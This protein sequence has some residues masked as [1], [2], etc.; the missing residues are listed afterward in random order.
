MKYSCDICFKSYVQQK[1]LHLHMKNFHECEICY[2][3]FVD[4]QTK[5]LHEMKHTKQV[6]SNLF[7]CNACNLTFNSMILFVQHI[8]GLNRNF[9]TLKCFSCDKEFAS[10]KEKEIHETNE[11]FVSIFCDVCNVLFTSKNML[12]FHK[13][14]FHFDKRPFTCCVCNVSFY[15]ENRLIEHQ[16]IHETEEPFYCD[17]CQASFYSTVCLSTHKQKEHLILSENHTGGELFKCKF[18]TF[19]TSDFSS[20]RHH[21]PKKHVSRSELS[22]VPELEDYLLYSLKQSKTNNYSGTNP[23]L[24]KYRI[25]KVVVKLKNIGCKSLSY[26]VNNLNENS[27]YSKFYQPVVK[28]RN[29]CGNKKLSNKPVV[30]LKRLR[31]TTNQGIISNIKSK[32]HHD[33]TVFINVSEEYKAFYDDIKAEVISDK[34]E[35]S[36]VNNDIS[37]TNNLNYK[38]AN[39]SSVF[40]NASEGVNSEE[41]KAFYDDIKAEAIADKIEDSTVNND[42][43]PINKLVSKSAN[44]SRIFINTSEGL[45]SEAFYDD[46]KAESIVVDEIE[47]ST[48]NEND[49]SFKKEDTPNFI[50]DVKK[51]EVEF[52]EEI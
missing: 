36:T 42:I 29:I 12:E 2:E 7:K 46:I 26:H 34:I 8:E 27:Y 45:N 19:T 28:L 37:T 4:Q 48:V 21:I 44:K 51:E 1:W 25:K 32:K 18:C 15:T 9:V 35:D 23:E 11:H 39:K 13:N 43:S 5:R 49:F 30:N 17:I 16:S 10:E 33:S 6:V 14:R 20:L 24:K 40:I 22:N 31:Q 52:K 41:Y 47:D 3:R 50:I 38:S